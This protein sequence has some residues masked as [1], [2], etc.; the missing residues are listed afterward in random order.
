MMHFDDISDDEIRIIG[1]SAAPTSSER[2]PRL[3]RQ[4]WFWVALI[5]LVVVSLLTLWSI[6]SRRFL[7]NYAAPKAG[8]DVIEATPTPVSPTLNKDEPAD[9]LVS[10]TLINDVPLQILIPVNAVPEL[11]L[12]IPDTLDKT[13]ILGLQAADIRADNHGIVGAFV[14]KGELLSRGVAKKGFCAILDGTVQLGMAESTPLFEEATSQDGYF[15]RQYPL[16]S[17]GRMVENKPKNKAVRHA[18]CELDGKIVIISSLDK[19]SFHDFAQSLA[20]LNVQ[21]AIS[22]V[23]ADAYGFIR[24]QE[25]GFSSWGTDVHRW[26]DAKNVNFV[27]W[28][29]YKTE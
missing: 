8:Y 19:E 11:S 7:D 17:N 12:G 2:K 4:W 6:H 20:D 23:G 14:L 22:L 9:V 1:N 25:T 28:R 5:V 26:K 21:N 3:Y 18:L 16:V 15:F 10:D 24:A 13:L 27:I 29:D